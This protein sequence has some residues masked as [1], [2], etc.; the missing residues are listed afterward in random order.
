MSSYLS[1]GSSHTIQF[2][3]WTSIALV[4]QSALWSHFSHFSSGYSKEERGK[5]KTKQIR[6][7]TFYREAY[8]NSLGS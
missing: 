8:N 5:K 1:I 2:A 6:P 3:W 4:F 7:K